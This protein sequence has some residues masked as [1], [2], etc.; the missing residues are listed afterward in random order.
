VYDNENAWALVLA[1]G[2]GSRLR[3][4]TTTPSGVHVPK[5]FCS[6]LN[7]PSLLHQALSRAQSIAPTE[8]VCTIVAAQHH[9]WWKGLPAS[10]VIV[11]PENRGTANGI[12]LALLHIAERDPSAQIVLVPSDHHVQDEPTLAESLRWACTHLRVRPHEVLLLGIAPEE[13]DPELGY[14]VPGER[15]RD[16][17]FE[18]VQFVEKPSAARARALIDNGA[19]WNV[20]IIAA[21]VHALLHMLEGRCP[22]IVSEMRVVVRKDLRQLNTNATV[23]LYER[24]PSLDFSRDILRNGT[25]ANLRVLPVPQCGWSDLG[26]SKRVV[27][28]LRQLRSR[29]GAIGVSLSMST[30][31]S[32]AERVERLRDAVRH[33]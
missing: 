1:A 10:N 19:L 20:F 18:V 12:I 3:E 9:R 17:T 6:L 13:P 24:L 21:S 14:I 26:T 32:L 29:R 16:G 15:S 11:Q 5:Q 23:E 33:P 28:T 25:D 30:Q 31:I 2:E 27:Q 4:L 22:E 8:R 7:G